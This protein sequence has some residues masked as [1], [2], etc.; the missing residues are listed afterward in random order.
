MKT[1]SSEPTRYPTPST[2]WRNLCSEIKPFWLCLL[3]ILLILLLPVSARAANGTWTNKQGG[4]W[5]LGGVNWAGSVIADGSGN[6]ADFSTLNLTNDVTVTLDG[7]R[8][9]GALLF[10]D[11]NSTKHN[12]TLTPGSGGTLMLAVSSGSP[13]INVGSATTIS[14]VVA[15]TSG[16]TKNGA[17]TL[18][19]SGNNTFTGD[20]AIY[21]GSLW[22]KQSNALGTG[23]KTVTCNN[24]TIGHCQLH[25]DGT[26]GNLTLS[27]G[28]NYLVSNWADPG[29]VYSEGGDNVINGNFTITMGGGGLVFLANAGS[30]TLNGN[31]SA[32]TPGR[33]VVFDGVGNSVANGVIS[34]GDGSLFLLMQGAGTATLNAANAYTGTTEVRSGTLLVNG[35]L[36]AASVVTV[37]TNATLGGIGAIGGPVTV[38]AGATLAPGIGIGW[39]GRMAINNTLSLAGTTAMHLNKAPMTNDQVRGI[40]TLTYGGTLMVTNLAGTLAAGDNFKLFDAAHYS[41]SFAAIS[42]ATPGIGIIWDRSYLPVDGTLRVTN[43]N[44]PCIAFDGLQ[45]CALGNATLNVTSNKLIVGNLGSSG[46]DGVRIALGN[47]VGWNAQL[48]PLD[49]DGTLPVDASI[50]VQAIGTAGVITNGLLASVQLTKTGSTNTAITADFSPLGAST[51]TL[52]AYTNGNCLAGELTGLTNGSQISA[53]SCPG[54]L[55]DAWDWVKVNVPT[56]HVFKRSDTSGG[57]GPIFVFDPPQA[58]LTFTPEGGAEV[59]SVT[60]AQIL[61]SQIPSITITNENLTVAEVWS[62][63]A[64][65]NW[66]IGTTANWTSAGSAA[67]Y[68]DG[69][70]VMFDDS[71]IGSTTVNLTT[72][73]SP[74]GVTVNNSALSYTFTGAGKLSDSVWLT[75][76]GSGVLTIANTNDYTGTTAINGGTV[77][78]NGSLLGGGAVNVT[79]G[80]TLGGTGVISG[81]VTV[82]AGATL[83]PGIGIGWIGR[84]AINNTLSLAGTLLMQVNR[85]NTPNCDQ[86]TGV[87]SVTGGGQLTVANSGPALLV[88]DKFTLFSQPLTGGNAL[89]VAGGGVVWVNNL[90][91][92]GSITVSAVLPPASIGF[93]IISGGGGFNLNWPANQGW[94]LQQT[95]NL[96]Y[97]W[98]DVTTTSNAYQVVPAQ[99]SQFFRLRS[100]P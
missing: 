79:D 46:Q 94:I 7:D 21:T 48:E 98:N 9:I 89:T 16:L 50:Q 68:T 42:P 88:G 76:N 6:T 40:T 84:I 83:S 3:A 71:A 70:E 96:L 52:R 1:K 54:W 47:G 44:S 24:G 59:G 82:Q 26:G 57:F 91:V 43:S 23:S 14:A 66:D 38:Q 45:H 4:T 32:N 77:R 19:L 34:D 12:W 97:P 67:T 85:T 8:T 17:G 60:A 93:Q 28:I 64:N 37:K 99:P 81:L 35:S 11:Q 80:G 100:G 5:D 18:T 39:I 2:N 51:F 62:G 55:K 92:D 90:A 73:L 15:G 31:I 10:D 58:L 53:M 75:K 30:L 29:T 13:V 25:L 27:S 41:G 95:T 61:A 49:P 86:L 72:A 22:I 74:A 56:I 33:G 87:T 63:T 78:V 20:V 65:G 36:A 69:D